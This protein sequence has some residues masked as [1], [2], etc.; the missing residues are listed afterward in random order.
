MWLL[1]Y[2]GIK[3]LTKLVKG[4]T[5]DVISRKISSAILKSIVWSASTYSKSLKTDWD[6][7]AIRV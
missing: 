2:P 4:D 5:I 6:L 1:I 7:N 3:S